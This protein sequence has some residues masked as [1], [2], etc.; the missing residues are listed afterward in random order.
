MDN[1]G[2]TDDKGDASD[3]GNKGDINN[4]SKQKR[5]REIKIEQC[6]ELRD[7]WTQQRGYK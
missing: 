5:N 6:Q 7:V 2:N 4:K 3:T 1:K